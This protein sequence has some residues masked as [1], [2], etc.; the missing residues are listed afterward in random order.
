MKT[1]EKLRI[2]CSNCKKPKGIHGAFDGQCWGKESHFK[3]YK[4]KREMPKNKNFSDYT[5]V[6]PKGIE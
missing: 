6:I 1:D 5:T 4:D 2:L 3:P